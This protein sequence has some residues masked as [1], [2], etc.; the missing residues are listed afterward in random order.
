MDVASFG[1]TSKAYRYQTGDYVIRRLQTMLKPAIQDYSRL[2]DVMR[3]TGAVISGSWCLHLLLGLADPVIWQPKDLDIYV[4][5]DETCVALIRYLSD[6]EGYTR[7]ERYLTSANGFEEGG[8]I[9]GRAEELVQERPE[10]A[11]PCDE[12]PEDA[13]GIGHVYKLTK[14]L[15]NGGEYT[16]D[17][18]ESIG[19]HPFRPI[20]HI[21]YTYLMNWIGA[22]IIVSLYPTLAPQKLGI[23]QSASYDK[24]RQRLHRI[25]KYKARGFEHA[26]QTALLKG[27]P[28]CGSAC[29]FVTRHLRDVGVM[30]FPLVEEKKASDDL[31]A[32]SWKT[33]IYEDC[34]SPK[35]PRLQKHNTSTVMCLNN[36]Y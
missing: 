22:D 19:V 29:C 16:I 14:R 13:R 6:Q 21:D 1:L 28:P 32:L 20:T 23:D 3:E 24:S 12:Y 33:G 7:V 30:E 26:R 34:L 4:P 36:R 18:I 9:N 35:C 10:D 17:V 27:R 8:G 5:Q 2:R 31:P 15:G 25:E 11:E